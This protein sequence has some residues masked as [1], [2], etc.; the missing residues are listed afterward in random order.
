MSH[1]QKIMEIQLTMFMN[2]IVNYY[3]QILKTRKQNMNKGPGSLKYKT[4]IQMYN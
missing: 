2:F 3:L 4:Y 1:K